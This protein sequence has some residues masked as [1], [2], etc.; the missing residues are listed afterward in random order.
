M[1]RDMRRNRQSLSGTECAE[2]LRNE[3]RGVMAVHGEN[4]YPYTFPMD[5]IYI[6]DKLYFHCALEGHKIDAIAGDNR[7]SFCVMD[8]GY[9]NDGEWFLNIKSV[10]VFGRIREIEEDSAKRDILYRFG[11]KYNPNADDVLDEIEKNFPRVR[12]LELSIEHMTGKL[13]KEK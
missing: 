7:V 9:R 1:F 5:F 4:G 8:K 2:I 3:P 10:I 13:V 11:C 6:G 12:V